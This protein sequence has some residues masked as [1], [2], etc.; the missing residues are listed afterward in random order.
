M[1]PLF[2]TSKIFYEFM[3]CS[4]GDL[5]HCQQLKEIILN[6]YFKNQIL[7]Q[8]EISSLDK[9]TLITDVSKEV[10]S[11][12]KRN[13]L[14]GFNCKARDLFTDEN[15]SQD[16]Q[17]LKKAFFLATGNSQTF[18]NKVK[19]HHHNLKNNYARG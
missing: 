14:S 12:A 4:D 13:N 9:K 5:K 2:D 15:F 19:A 17:D 7:K 6:S 10:T 3:M 11:I 8:F 18:F 16:C 1:M